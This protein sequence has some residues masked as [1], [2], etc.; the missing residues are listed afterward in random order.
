MK[1]CVCS[2]AYKKRIQWNFSNP[3]FQ[4]PEDLFDLERFSN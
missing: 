2:V 3:N 1:A 4:G